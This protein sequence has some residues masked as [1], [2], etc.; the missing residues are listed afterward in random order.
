M[1]HT[2]YFRIAAKFYQSR[3]LPIN[4]ITMPDEDF[5]DLLEANAWEPFDGWKG[6]N[7]EAEIHA[8]QET[9][10]EIASDAKAEALKNINQ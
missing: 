4:Y 6:E 3:E 7:I 2:D 9:M 10:R 5:Y 1:K 8:L